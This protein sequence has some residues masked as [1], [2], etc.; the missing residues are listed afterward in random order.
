MAVLADREPFAGLA[1]VHADQDLVRAGRRVGIDGDVVAVGQAFTGLPSGG[2]P[3][4]VDRLVVEL[5]VQLEIGAEELGED[6]VVGVEGRGCRPV[7]GQVQQVAG[8]VVGAVEIVPD[9]DA[10]RARLERLA[11]ALDSRDS[12]IVT[13]DRTP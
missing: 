3:Q 12:E 5:A 2:R 7:E 10:V 4:V 6:G 13:T 9:S 8:V 11:K 1:V